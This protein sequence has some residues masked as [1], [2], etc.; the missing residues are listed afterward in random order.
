MATATWTA[1]GKTLTA[2]GLAAQHARVRS[3]ASAGSGV[4]PQAVQVASG[5]PVK[6]A[7]PPAYAAAVPPFRS[8]GSSPRGR[9]FLVEEFHSRLAEAEWQHRLAQEVGQLGRVGL[10]EPRRLVANTGSQLGLRGG[11]FVAPEKWPTLL[12]VTW[13]VRADILEIR[14]EVEED[15]KFTAPGVRLTYRNRW[16][17]TL[18]VVADRVRR[19]GDQVRDVARWAADP[20]ERYGSR[21]W[22][23]ERWTPWVIAAGG[24]RHWDD[25]PG[26]GPSPR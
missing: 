4:P 10:W 8:Q 9:Q 25:I 1:T 5:W 20:S 6:F 17:Q 7:Q 26:L 14:T 15:M 11:T 16:W 13:Q 22:D 19:A 12:T 24:E 23:G 21:Y 3:F 18:N 2:D